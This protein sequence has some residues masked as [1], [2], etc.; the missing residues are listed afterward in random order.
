M[1]HCSINACMLHL[2]RP[3]C[4]LQLR[5]GALLLGRFLPKL[6]RRQKC[7]RFFE[8]RLFCRKVDPH[9]IS[10]SLLEA[11]IP[12]SRSLANTGFEAVAT[13]ECVDGKLHRSVR[14]VGK[15]VWNVI[16]LITI[17]RA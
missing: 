8:C 12:Q 2:R 6:R 10:R 1:L 11:S 4:V 5:F 9:E 3:F 16:E 13:I 15:D 17:Y 14:A 7:R